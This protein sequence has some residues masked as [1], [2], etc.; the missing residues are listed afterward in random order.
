MEPAGAGLVAAPPPLALALRLD[1]GAASSMP[2][3]LERRSVRVRTPRL[4]ERA[5]NEALTACQDVAAILRETGD[6][7]SEGFALRRNLEAAR[8]AAEDF[9]A[10]ASRRHA[11]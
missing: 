8:A 1:R 2:G 11:A 10:C 3:G 5:A 4:P 7:H 6:R 9:M